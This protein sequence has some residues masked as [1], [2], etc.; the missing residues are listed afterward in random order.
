MQWES[1]NEQ[2]NLTSIL[3]TKPC[4]KCRKGVGG[5]KKL[6]TNISVEKKTNL[7]DE[8]KKIQSNSN[9]GN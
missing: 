8:W 6:K 9:T 5:R 7:F 4:L 3:H 1:Q 2:E